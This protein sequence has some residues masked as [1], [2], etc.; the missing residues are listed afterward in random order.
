[1]SLAIAK[2]GQ[3][4]DAKPTGPRSENHE[5][6]RMAGLPKRFKCLEFKV[7]LGAGY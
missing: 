2:P 4:G 1:M 3:P 6:R 5:M 7:I